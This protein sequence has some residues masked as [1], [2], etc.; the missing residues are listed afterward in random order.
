MSIPEFAFVR[1]MRAVRILRLRRILDRALTETVQGRIVSLLFII[2][3]IIFCTSAA[4]HSIAQYNIV[5][6][7]DDR[8]QEGT[9]WFHDA[10]YFVVCTITTIGYGDVSPATAASRMITVIAIV[11]SFCILPTHFQKLLHTLELQLAPY[12]RRFEHHSTTPHHVVITGQLDA[13]NCA[14]FLQE[15]FHQDH[16]PRNKNLKAVLLT[17]IEPSDR[18]KALLESPAYSHCTTILQGS[19]LEDR[20]LERAATKHA[21]AVFVLTDYRHLGGEGTYGGSLIMD[22]APSTAIDEANMLRAMSVRAFVGPSVP[23]VT[24]VHSEEMLKEAEGTAMG[25]A[26]LTIAVETI[27]QNILAKT[28]HC[29]GFS[30]LV[31]NLVSSHSR[32]YN[33]LQKNSGQWEPWEKEYYR[34]CSHEIYRTPLCPPPHRHPRLEGMAFTSAADCIYRQFGAMLIGVETVMDS[35]SEHGE[36]NQNCGLGGMEALLKAYGGGAGG[37]LLSPGPSFLIGASTVGFIVC[38]NEEVRRI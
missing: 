27:K 19:P 24:Q 14:T 15:L 7:N 25:T 37:V 6:F 36:T 29:T 13:T 12:N 4:I 31:A 33:T 2:A 18:L 5:A 32:D 16:F 21:A 3:S 28:C 26:G 38:Q 8:S 23:V 35:E 34:G 9:F 20:D 22:A 1:L 17:P 10:L 11:T 30:T